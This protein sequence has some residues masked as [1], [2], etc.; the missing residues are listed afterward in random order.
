MNFKIAIN[1]IQRIVREKL[2]LSKIP[3]LASTVN[4]RKRLAE[5]GLKEPYDRTQCIRIAESIITEVQKNNLALSPLNDVVDSVGD[6]EDAIAPQEVPQ[7][8]LPSFAPNDLEDTHTPESTTSLTVTPEA[9]EMISF[10]AQSM[11]INLV[12]SQISQIAETI[13]FENSSFTQVLGQVKAG[14]LAYIEFNKGLESGQVTE[15]FSEVSQALEQKRK[16]VNEQF[17]Q[18]FAKISK[19]INTQA[20]EQKKELSQIL[21]RLKVPSK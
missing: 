4:I 17:T 15:M 10:Q 5:L 12:E 19:E 2:E 6:S 3:D 14:I 20:N 11:G 16:V 13:D 7:E 8:Q 1:Y 9:T 21:L 18:G